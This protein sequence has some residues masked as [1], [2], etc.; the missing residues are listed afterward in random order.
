MT[1]NVVDF[2]GDTTLPVDPNKVLKSA[3][4][5]LDYVILVG[6]DKEGEYWFAASHSDV[7]DNLLLVERF[8]EFLLK[9]ADNKMNW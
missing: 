3:M 8:K 7:G 9:E 2:T 6:V 4:D 5:Q 1:D